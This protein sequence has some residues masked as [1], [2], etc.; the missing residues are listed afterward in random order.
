M[1]RVVEKMTRR[2]WFW[3][4]ISIVFSIPVIIPYLHS[5]FF[6]TH[7]GEWAV[8]RLAEMFR[9]L[10]DHQLPARFSTY[11]NNGYGYP[12]FNFT[13][14]FP[15]YF[16]IIFVLLKIGFVNSIKILFAGSVVVS[17][18][19]MYL[20]SERIWHS[21]LSGLV[22][23]VFYIYLPYRMVDLYVRGN[24][25]E[26]IGMALFPIIIY[27]IVRIAQKPSW[28]LTAFAAV[29]VAVL[30]LTHNI[31]ALVFAPLILVFM[32]VMLDDRYKKQLIHFFA[33]LVLG[34]GLAAFFWIPA[35]AE[36]H[37]ILLSKIPIADRS[38]YFVSLKQFILPSWGYGVPT[39][40]HD[41]FSYQLGWPLLI[42]IL[43]SFGLM[44]FF[45]QKKDSERDLKRGLI[46]LTWLV[47]VA[48][49]FPF[50]AVI[51]K[52]VPLLSDINYPWTLLAP[53]GFLSSLM[54]GFLIISK[55]FA[56]VGVLLA[57][58]SVIIF[59]PYAKPQQYVNRGE[60][61][62]STND[63]T[64]TSSQELMP[65]WV[66][67]FPL[68]MP[69]Q[70]IEVITGDIELSN[71]DENSKSFSAEVTA[72]SRGRLRINTIYYPGWRVMLNGIEKPISYHNDNGMMEV[73]VPP[74]SFFLTGK[75]TETPLRFATDII[76]FISASILGLAFLYTGFRYL[77]KRL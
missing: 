7:D 20:A 13:Y 65:L 46:F 19:F 35:I 27:F 52:S 6:P 69:A 40:S 21:K 61:F 22:S 37:N 23:A 4:T 77:R 30:V 63:A 57:V 24:I 26:S 68:F 1:K 47:Y 53:I 55:K 43:L 31:M 29:G 50:T 34:F 73:A 70:H 38:L 14:P 72:K 33:V 12:L 2:H 15:Y 59:L 75:F 51:W 28:S 9:E 49:L 56:W 74:G 18:V 64:T 42:A 67:K 8:V 58:I 25:G 5:G 32:V 62:Y 36:K 16:G 11:L 44:F 76:S 66:K 48:L 39:S 17:S 54:I 60:G 10:H 71:I 3:I 41:A 45:N